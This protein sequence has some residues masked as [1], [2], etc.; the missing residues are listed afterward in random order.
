MAHQ[1]IWTK[2]TL[3]KFVEYGNLSDLEA[4]IM[5]TRIAGWTQTKQADHYNISLST[6]SRMIKKLKV[7]YDTVQQQHPD[8]LPPRR[9]SA[10]ET[11]MDD[12]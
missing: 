11:Y 8:E 6:L 9:F 12:H 3:D 4:E 2:D 10:K 7:V 5:R 1:V